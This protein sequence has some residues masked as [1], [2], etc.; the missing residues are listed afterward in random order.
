MHRLP[1]LLFCLASIFTVSSSFAANDAAKQTDTNC[2]FQ[3]PRLDGPRSEPQITGL[4]GFISNGQYW[5]SSTSLYDRLP[6]Y[7]WKVPIYVKVGPQT[8]AP[9]RSS[10]A[11][12]TEVVVLYQHLSHRGHGIYPGLLTVKTT[13]NAQELVID[14][15]N[16][17]P[18]DYW[19]CRP[20]QAI[21]YGPFIGEII[22]LNSRPVDPRSGRWVEYGGSKRV[23]CDQQAYPG[24]SHGIVEGVMCFVYS[25]KHKGH[26]TRAIFPS[27]AL[28]IVY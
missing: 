22:D 8:W 7:P 12:K 14:V 10:I 6:Q 24:E 16:F 26:G 5:H 21:K 9:S 27:S 17:V 3:I 19:N 13:K 18:T 15:N 25:A 11:A 2:A 1:P 4:R 28:R 23:F 20:F